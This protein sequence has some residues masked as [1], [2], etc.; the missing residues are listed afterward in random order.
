MRVATDGGRRTAGARRGFTLLEVIVFIAIFAVTIMAFMTIFVSVSKVLV[1]QGGASEVAQQSQFLLQNLQYYIERS[2]QV[3]ITA[4]AA[5]TSLRLRMPEASQDPVIFNLSGNAITLQVGA[6]AASALTSGKVKVNNL[7]FVRRT[8]VP[9]HD[10]VAVAFTLEYNTQN[11]TQKFL[12]S[13]NTS[14]ARVSAATFDS[15]VLPSAGSLNLGTGV[16]P[17][18]SINGVITFSGPNVGI[19]VTPSAKLQVSGGDVYIDTA[20]KGLILKGPSGTACWRVT[21]TDAGNIA[22]TSVAC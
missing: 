21:I 19:G 20:T 6:G 16:S 13:L 9:G 14:V 1:R 15:D 2:S 8:N 7:S 17:W 10:S 5:T 18:T 3:D 12:Q 4:D 22:T 11:L